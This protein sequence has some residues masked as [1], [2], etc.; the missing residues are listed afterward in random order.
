[1][2]SCLFCAF[3]ISLVVLASGRPNE[4]DCAPFK[5]PSSPP[6]SNEASICTMVQNESPYLV[7]WIEYHRLIGISHFYIY[8]DRGTDDTPARLKPYIAAGVVDLIYWDGNLTV[9]ASLVPEDPPYTKNQ[10][11]ALAD[12][13]YKRAPINSKWVGIWD[14]DEFLYTATDKITSVPALIRDYAEP[15]G[16]T[17]IHLPSTLVGPSNFERRPQGLVIDNYRWRS[18]VVAFGYVEHKT[19]GFSGKTFYRADCAMPEVHHSPFPPYFCRNGDW[20]GLIEDGG[21]RTDY[22]S[23]VLLKHYKSKSYEDFLEK[24]QKWKIGVHHLAQTNW[25]TFQQ[26][27]KDE[28]Q[29]YD[30]DMLQFVKQVTTAISCNSNLN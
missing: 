4:R 25:T 26:D 19:V 7:E 14:I 17:S 9:D 21:V 27:H 15:R 11:S 1:M 10:R 29:V 30:L 12:C 24:T 23:P 18:G 20:P 28:Y 22:E 8:N 3:L 13:V 16:W 5:L 6:A 2:R